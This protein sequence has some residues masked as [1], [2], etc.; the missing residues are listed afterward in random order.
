MEQDNLCI[1]WNSLP[2]KKFR[3]KSSSLQR[4]IYEAKQNENKKSIKRLQKL[5]LKS[6]SLYYIAVKT[7]TDYYYFKGVFLSQ[8]I[9]LDLVNEVYLR[10]SKGKNSVM[11]F[12]FRVNFSKLSYLKDE[13]VAYIMNFLIKSVYKENNVTHKYRLYTF[14]TKTSLGDKHLL[15]LGFKILPKISFLSTISFQYLKSLLTVPVKYKSI[16]LR[17][18]TVLTSDFYFHVC[19][20]NF[21]VNLHSL[22]FSIVLLHLKN[23]NLLHF[24][25]ELHSNQKDI[26]SYITKTM[27]YFTQTRLKH[28]Q[29][30]FLCKR[31]FQILRLKLT[32]DTL[33]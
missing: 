30:L 24:L 8:K 2:W 26:S 17:S 27:S 13:V 22:Y 29:L 32:F 28:E 21:R 19:P 15:K 16:I 3:R 9:K 7:V 18:L 6:K 31:V 33:K 4:K 14:N 5:L 10:L 11:N 12:N 1:S 20:L 25:D 23:S